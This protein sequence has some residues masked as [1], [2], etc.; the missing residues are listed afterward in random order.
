MNKK[1]LGII[2]AGYIAEKHLEVINKITSLEVV[3]ITSRTNSKAKK[4]AKNFSI[5]NVYNNLDDLIKDNYLDAILILVSPEEMF[6]TINK[7]IAYKIPFFTEKPPSLNLLD[8]NILCR[9]VNKYNI[10]NM[11]GYN[12]RYYSTF[13]KGLKIIKDKGKLLGFLIEGHER[14]WKVSKSVNS[15]NRENWLYSNASHT[16][17]LIRF[18][19][20]D[21]KNISINKSSYIEKNGDQISI[22]IK[23]INKVIGT[24]ISNWYSP[25]GWSVR[26]YG[27]GV[28]VKIKPL[29]KAVWY[30]TKMKKHPL[31]E[32]PN[33]IKFKPGFYNQMK[34]FHKLLE[35]GILEHPAQDLKEI[36]KTFNLIKKII[37]A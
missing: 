20:G 32:D 1:F 16:I 22:S 3:A 14:F 6:V 15:V 34:A 17:D 18:F 2:G 26:L 24:Y 23:F 10:T 11:V 9:K 27:E 35:S 31:K 21:I 29:E 30:D 7:V 25:G 12:R 4:L 33:D 36:S 37:D 8:L 5:N 13:K 19:G 28:T